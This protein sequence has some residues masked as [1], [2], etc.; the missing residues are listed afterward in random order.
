MVKTRKITKIL[1]DKS[2]IEKLM[3]KFHCGRASVYNALA[4]RTNSEMSEKIRNE[5]INRYGGIENRF[6]LPT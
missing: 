2:K 3:D 6:S 1:V 4:Y 5:A